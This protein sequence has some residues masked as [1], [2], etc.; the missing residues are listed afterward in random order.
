MSLLLFVRWLS[1]TSLSI[2]I[3]RS[4]WAFAEIEM[5]H[6][7][8]L[9]IFGGSVLVVDLR[10]LGARLRRQSLSEVARR[11]LPLTLTSLG[12]LL[13]SGGLMVT[14]F[15]MK[16]YCS[17]SFR[18]KMLLLLLATLFYFTFHRRFVVRKADESQ[19]NSFWSR[20]A[21]L[22]SLAL[23]LGVGLAGRAIGFF[24]AIPL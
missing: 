19:A 5:V 24:G 2:S 11:L 9:A 8:A 10:L 3:R 7:L 17:P 13:V 15:P 12:V 20:A 4:T 14:A 18:V 22:I 6:L 16:Y 1:H 23:W 21:A